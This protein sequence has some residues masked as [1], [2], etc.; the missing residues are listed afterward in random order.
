MASVRT[1]KRKYIPRRISLGLDAE[2]H[3]VPIQSTKGTCVYRGCSLGGLQVA[4][5]GLSLGA[6]YCE[7]WDLSGSGYRKALCCQ[8][9]HL[10]ACLACLILAPANTKHS[11]VSSCHSW[12]HGSRVYRVMPEQEGISIVACYQRR[13]GQL[14]AVRRC[15]LETAWKRASSTTA[16]AVH[17]AG[18]LAVDWSV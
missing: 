1:F 12:L 14:A 17:P 9:A 8:H 10:M 2:L 6:F 5:A 18:F 11:G 15:V 7:V 16:T 13:C 3:L 4:I